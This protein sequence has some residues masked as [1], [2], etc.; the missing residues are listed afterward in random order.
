VIDL[1][2]APLT[3]SPA[4]EF[5][6]FDA[7]VPDEQRVSAILLGAIPAG[8]T[9]EAQLAGLCPA[10]VNFAS[11]THKFARVASGNKVL[12]SNAD[13]GPARVAVAPGS[14]GEQM[15]WV[16]LGSSSAAAPTLGIPFINTSSETAPPGACMYT[17]D[18]TVIGGLPF[19]QVTKPTLFDRFWLING[20][21]AVASGGVGLGSFLDDLVGFVAISTAFSGGVGTAIS[22]GPRPNS[23]LLHQ[24]RL[25][26]TPLDNSTWTINGQLCGYFRQHHVLDVLG[27]YKE[28]LEPA[29]SGEAGNK[30]LFEI[31]Y[32]NQ[33]KVLHPAG[34]SD[35]DVY[36]F[37]LNRG[38]KI[39]KGTKG[40]ALW[41][42]GYWES[43][44]SMCDP[45]NTNESG[46]SAFLAAFALPDAALVEPAYPPEPF[47]SSL[48]QP[49]ITP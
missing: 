29:V 20:Q 14:T 8:D 39:R 13:S 1:S 3:G 23:W 16:A 24:Y 36:D 27:K 18:S 35:I 12:Q 46:T 25:G 40:Q 34:W 15:V 5:P 4:R 42:S 37:F 33:N 49:V 32:R 45:D 41:K 38:E 11:T 19:L 22:W 6:W 26:F 47:D 21:T 43:G 17:F 28:D 31:Y 9:G 30:A 7:A 44:F 10:L 2:S 48:L